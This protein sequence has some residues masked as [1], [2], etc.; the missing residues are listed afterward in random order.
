MKLRRI[1]VSYFL[2]FCVVL[3]VGIVLWLLHTRILYTADSLSAEYTRS[4]SNLD[5]SDCGQQF[6]VSNNTLYFA[7][8]G[9]I[10][11]VKNNWVSILAKTPGTY[12]RF[13]ILD[14]ET[15][16]LEKGDTLY[17]LNKEDGSLTKLWQGNSVGHYGNQVYFTCD[18][19][20][21]AAEVTQGE[22]K[23]IVV[24]DELLGAYDDAIVYRSAGCIYQLL[25]REPDT[26]QLLVVGEIPWPEDVWPFFNDAYLYTHDYALYISATA[27]D[28]YTYETGEMKRIYDIG[29]DHSAIMAVTARKNELYVSRQWVDVKLWPLRSKEING[30]YRYDMQTDVWTKITGKTYKTIARFDERSVYVYG[31]WGKV[32]RLRDKGTVSV[33]TGT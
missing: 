9:D 32:E 20:L 22:P 7:T 26:S 15:V 16:I 14:D 21:Y 23:E 8:Q 2:V 10:R 4:V 17:W 13:V 29:T 1:K 30:T 27:I 5:M 24:F 11:Y 25:F 19:T 12:E 18:N 33:K 31:S 6:Y 3:F 28:M